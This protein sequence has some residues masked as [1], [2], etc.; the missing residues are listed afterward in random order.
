M[1]VQTAV[2]ADFEN[3]LRYGLEIFADRRCGRSAAFVRCRFFLRR[4]SFAETGGYFSGICGR[5]PSLVIEEAVRRISDSLLVRTVIRCLF[6]QAIPGGGLSDSPFRFARTNE[7]DVPKCA[8]Q[9]IC[10]SI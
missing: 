2:R 5:K 6:E 4:T 8:E 9:G 3:G 1:P 7:Y 10:V